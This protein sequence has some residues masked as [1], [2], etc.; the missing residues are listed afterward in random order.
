M[1][2][3]TFALRFLQ[4]FFLDALPSPSYD[5]LSPAVFNLSVTPGPK[6]VI[7]SLSPDLVP[8]LSKLY[9]K[10]YPAHSQLFDKEEIFVPSTFRQ[11]STIKWHG[12]NL[13]AQQCCYVYVVPPFPFSSESS[14][15]FENPERLAK[16]EYF[17]LHTISIPAFT[18]PSSH[19]LASLRWPI[20]HPH[21]HFYGKPIEV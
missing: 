19:L 20:I 15:A 9:G 18:E 12:K 13:N 17:M 5:I 10:L 1:H 4:F 14:A 2:G 8:C 16:V 6:S 21:R 7:T 3:I 11:Y